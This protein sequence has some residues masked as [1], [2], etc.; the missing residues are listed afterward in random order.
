[1]LD[2][3]IGTKSTQRLSLEQQADVLIL[4]T[5]LAEL[6]PQAEALYRTGRAQ[7]LMQLLIERR[8]VW[9]ARPNL[10]LAFRSAPAA[11]RL[12][13]HCRLGASEYVHQWSGDDFAQIGA[14]HRDE[15]RQSLWPWLRNR[16]Y[17]GPE[18]D[19]Q[20]D[21]FLNRLGRRDVHLRPSLEVTRSWPWAQAVDLDERGAMTS[22]VRTAVAELLSALGEPLPPGCVV[23]R[24][25][26]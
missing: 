13:P 24:E 3:A 10:H 2:S 7:G 1:M 9:Y 18:D 8:A 21:A 16:Q 5:W 11:Q 19:E 20:L 4:R 14:H 12:Y 17:A 26:G 6:K 23:K 22:N 15:I 25:E